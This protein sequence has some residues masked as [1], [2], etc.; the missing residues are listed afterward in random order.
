M[1]W[2]HAYE[3]WDQN[4]LPW[5]K[6]FTAWR[7]CLY[8]H[9]QY[10]HAEQ[11]YNQALFMREK[12]LG[13][14]HRD[15]AQSLYGLAEIYCWK[16]KKFE[17]AETLLQRA[18]TIY[19]KAQLLDHPELAQI[20]KT[21]ANLLVYLNRKTEAAKTLERYKTISPKYAGD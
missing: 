3:Y 13:L 12:E 16:W 20:L 7:T 14:E 1:F 9:G 15:V 10:A 11:V 17:M 6:L 19:E 2:L 4:T 8:F 21:Y 18:I 5:P